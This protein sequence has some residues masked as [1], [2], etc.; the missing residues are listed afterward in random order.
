MF[1]VSANKR[2]VF[3]V[4]QDI[5]MQGYNTV[6]SV[7]AGITCRNRRQSL[8]TAATAPAPGTRVRCVVDISPCKSTVPGMEVRTN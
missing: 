5:T 2:D 7:G 1:Y 6:L 3:C 8:R 4:L